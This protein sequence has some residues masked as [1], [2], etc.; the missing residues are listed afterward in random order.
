MSNVNDEYERGYIARALSHYH[1]WNLSFLR[2][3]VVPGDDEARE[4]E[5]CDYKA[6]QE[7]FK[8]LDDKEHPALAAIREELVSR[9]V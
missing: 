2:P 3:G 5:I 8:R 4:V 7:Y 1:Q 6:A 9:N